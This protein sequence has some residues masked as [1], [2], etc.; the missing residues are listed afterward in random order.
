MMNYKIKNRLELIAKEMGVSKW[1]ALEAESYHLMISLE[2]SPRMKK[3]DMVIAKNLIE[4]INQVSMQSE[5]VPLD[6][7][8][9]ITPIM[10]EKKLCLKRA[11][12][13]I[14][15]HLEI[16]TLSRPEQ[17]F[18]FHLNEYYETLAQSLGVTSNL[19]SLYE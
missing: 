10:V 17:A 7:L 2:N 9:Q 13:A 3:G 6:F 16:L 18:A 11:L 12:F 15:N 1:L 5:E 14:A 4:Y 19:E 8:K